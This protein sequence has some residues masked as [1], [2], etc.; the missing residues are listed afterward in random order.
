MKVMI[1]TVLIAALVAAAVIAAWALKFKKAQPKSKDAKSETCAVTGSET[2]CVTTQ[3]LIQ[4]AGFDGPCAVSLD[5]TRV[6]FIHVE[7]KNLSFATAYERDTDAEAV[8]VALA[9]MR[10]P[11]RIHRCQRPIDATVPAQA[12]RAQLGKIEEESADVRSGAAGLTGFAAEKR[13]RALA[14]RRELIEQIYLPQASGEGSTKY[15]TDIYITMGF[16][17]A[18]DAA[19][20]AQEEAAAFISLLSAAGYHANIMYPDQ[21]VERI[22]NYYGRFPAKTENRDPYSDHDMSAA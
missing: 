20:R 19:L 5:G 4:V 21:V 7:G 15:E 6:V 18:P 16:K 8:G 22:T 3:D 9:G 11:Y 12:L 10:H 17:E 13:L 1:A 14:A 2:A